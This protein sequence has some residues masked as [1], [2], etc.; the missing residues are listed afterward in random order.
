MQEQIPEIIFNHPR[1]TRD[2]KVMKLEEFFKQ[3][4]ILNEI[5]QAHRLKFFQMLYI[6]NGEGRHMVDFD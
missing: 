1:C 2:F 6:T 5:Y 3:E 4:A